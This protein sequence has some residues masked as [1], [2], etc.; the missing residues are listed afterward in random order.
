MRIYAKLGQENLLRMDGMSEMTLNSKFEP[1]RSEAEH[2]SSRSR[3][4]PT[5]GSELTGKST[6][7]MLSWF[8]V[9]LSILT[10]TAR[11]WTLVVR[12]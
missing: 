7:I 9:I 12:I 1:W 8:N 5:I 2:A 4:L 3:K 6:K 10:F 11:G